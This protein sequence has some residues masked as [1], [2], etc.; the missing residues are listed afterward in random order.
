M[1]VDNIHINPLISSLELQIYL[2]SLFTIITAQTIHFVSYFNQPLFRS[3][4][5]G[6]CRL[7][8]LVYSN[9]YNH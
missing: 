2:V 3:T 8:Y 4:F 9:W 5:V 7:E 1:R 6:Y